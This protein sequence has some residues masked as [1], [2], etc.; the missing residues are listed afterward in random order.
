MKNWELEPVETPEKIEELCALAAEIWQEYFT[1]ILE[2]GQ[3]PY[4]VEKFQ[5]VPAVTRQIEEQGYEYRLMKLNGKAVGYTG[6]HLEADELFLS[7]LYV[8]KSCRG[9]GLSRKT[10]DWLKERCRA[11]GKKAIWLTVN[12]YNTHTIEVYRHYGFEVIREEK[13]DIGGG[14]YMDDFIM[15][16]QI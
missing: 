16:V 2:P 3:V 11:E 12:R 13:N 4:M 7:K 6:F 15:E 8:H 1:P 10:F 5:S 9:M 14:Y